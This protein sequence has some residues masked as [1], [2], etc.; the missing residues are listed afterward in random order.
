MAACERQ[1][2]EVEVDSPICRDDSYLKILH[3]PHSQ[4]ELVPDGEGLYLAKLH[5]QCAVVAVLL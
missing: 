4:L 5:L 2:V 3:P 1:G